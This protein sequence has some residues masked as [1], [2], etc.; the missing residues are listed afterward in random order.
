MILGYLNIALQLSLLRFYAG[1]LRLPDV[2][3]DWLRTQISIVNQEPVLFATT[4]AENI[5]YGKDAT[6][7][8]V[9]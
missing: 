9:C 6:E 4:I 3:L 5:A 8:E 7:Q 2:D 1:N